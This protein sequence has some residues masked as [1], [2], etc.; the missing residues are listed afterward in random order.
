[1]REHLYLPSDRDFAVIKRKLKLVDRVYCE[2]I[3]GNYCQLKSKRKFLSV[4]NIFSFKCGHI[5]TRTP[6]HM[7]LFPMKYQKIRSS[8]SLLEKATNSTTAESYQVLFQP[9]TK[10]DGLTVNTFRLA[11][12]NNVSLPCK[13]AYDRPL[14]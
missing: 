13:K 1:M 2:R 10:K 3:C 9:T 6:C 5:I 11:V 12:C 8:L 4:N 14:P 7:N